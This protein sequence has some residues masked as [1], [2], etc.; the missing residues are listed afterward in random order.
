MSRGSR[1][2]AGGRVVDQRR[3]DLPA[4]RLGTGDDG[5]DA[6]LERGGRQLEG[7]RAARM[8]LTLRYRLF[9]GAANA[10]SIAEGVMP[11]SSALALATGQ[12]TRRKSAARASSMRMASRAE[13]A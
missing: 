9:C 11:R 1:A 2:V 5:V 4:W 3:D 13:S 7:V 6:L 12:V 10:S 8:D